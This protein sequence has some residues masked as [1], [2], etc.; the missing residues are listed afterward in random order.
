VIATAHG[1]IQK[2]GIHFAQRPDH[3]LHRVPAQLLERRHPLVAVDDQVM[4]RLLGGDHDDRHLL[5]A[6]RQR[7][8]QAPMT[9]RPMHTKVLQTPLKLV[10]FQPHALGPLRNSNL[11]QIPSGIARRSGVVSPDLLWNQYDMQPTGIARSE[12]VVLP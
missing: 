5:A 8:Q 6:G 3:S 7:C 2:Q 11:H 9:L 1:T 4:L 12:A 10:P